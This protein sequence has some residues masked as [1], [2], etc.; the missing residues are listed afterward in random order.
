[1]TEKKYKVLCSGGVAEGKNIDDVKARMAALFKTN[2]SKIGVLFQGKEAVIKKDVDLETAK[3]YI[4]AILS[5][6]AVCRIDPPEMPS[7]KTPVEVVPEVVSEDV[8]AEVSKSEETA[9]TEPR[10]VEIPL[11]RKGE[12]KYAPQ[13]I[14]KVTSVSGGL[15]FNKMDQPEI[16][17]DQIVSLMTYIEVKGGVETTMLHLYTTTNSR[18]YACDMKSIVYSDFPM[19]VGSNTTISFRNLLYFLCRQNPNIILEE[20]TFDFLSGSQPQKLD[21]VKALKLS[22]GLGQLIESGDISAQL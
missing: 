10:V 22:T 7:P 9:R 19:K 4:R 5:T 17:F 2:V 14:K 15:N 6:G 12:F 13:I 8:V 18:P 3:K 1:M 21:E 16:S 11:M 20:T